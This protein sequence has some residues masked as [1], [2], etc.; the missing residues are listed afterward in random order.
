MVQRLADRVSDFEGSQS[1]L[2]SA[3]LSAT[4]TAT[5][6]NLRNGSDRDSTAL[7]S[8]L[9]V[10]GTMREVGGKDKAVSDTDSCSVTAE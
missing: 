8:N 2:I 7:F 6:T 10:T 3:S 9:S 5:A 1:L 4:C